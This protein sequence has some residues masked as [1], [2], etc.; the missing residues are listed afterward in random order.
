MG[1]TKNITNI[2]PNL[3]E[4]RGKSS[5]QCPCR[6]AGSSWVWEKYVTLW[7]PISSPY[8]RFWFS[9]NLNDLH[10]G[11]LT[12]NLK[13]TYLKRKI[14]FQTSIIMF[15]VNLPGCMRFVSVRVWTPLKKSSVVTFGE[16]TDPY[17]FFI[18]R[19]EEAEGFL[20]IFSS[21]FLSKVEIPQGAV[22]GFESKEPS[23]ISPYENTHTQ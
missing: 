10:P 13:I 7:D 3:G 15:H 23:I 14:I 21:M 20:L 1:T 18:C 12:W 11:R 17:R 6:L 2:P 8:L 9:C 4:V 16:P 22:S 5:I 19:S